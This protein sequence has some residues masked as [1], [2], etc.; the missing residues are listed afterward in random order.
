MRNGN[1]IHK[2][3]CMCV[4]LSGELKCKFDVVHRSKSLVA[5]VALFADGFRFASLNKLAL[6]I[7]NCRG[8]CVG[9]QFVAVTFWMLLVDKF[10]VDDKFAV[11]GDSELVA[12]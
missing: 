12:R 2:Y 1:R 6:Q 5:A 9:M 11:P 10:V 3:V 4:T 7:P 8:F